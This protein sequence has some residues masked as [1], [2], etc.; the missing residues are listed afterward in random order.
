MLLK[1]TL[2]KIIF[3]L[4]KNH[5]ITN[6]EESLKVVSSKLLFYSKL[7]SD[8]EKTISINW[9]EKSTVVVSCTKILVKLW[10]LTLSKS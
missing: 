7:L 10:V 6:L 4:R 9:E 2:N 1:K 3:L 5:K 8:S